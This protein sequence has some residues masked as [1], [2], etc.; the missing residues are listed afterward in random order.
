M[1]MANLKAPS[2]LDRHYGF[3]DTYGCRYG[4]FTSIHARP[5]LAVWQSQLSNHSL[6]EM[7]SP[8]QQGEKRSSIEL[9]TKSK[10]KQLN[11]AGSWRLLNL[12]APVE[13]PRPIGTTY[14]TKCKSDHSIHLH[15]REGN[16]ASVCR[17]VVTS[18]KT[19]QRELVELISGSWIRTT[20][21]GE[22]VSDRLAALPETVDPH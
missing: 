11:G 13:N 17:L 6:S 15:S 20:P 5:S 4:P 21:L 16:L 10:R 2:R 3:D 9:S 14:H 18:F 1:K 7:G 8:D 12:L 19:L 22:Q